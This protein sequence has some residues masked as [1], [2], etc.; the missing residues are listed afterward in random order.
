M[1]HS[2][3]SAVHFSFAFVLL[4]SGGSA[5]GSAGRRGETAVIAA[6]ALGTW[7]WTSVNV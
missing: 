2:G 5:A 1:D 4:R 6:L 3:I 7:Q